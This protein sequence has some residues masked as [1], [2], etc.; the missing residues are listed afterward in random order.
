MEAAA[1]AGDWGWWVT[2][3]NVMH[4]QLLQTVQGRMAH[5]CAAGG[6]KLRSC[7]SAAKVVVVVM[8]VLVLVLVWRL[9]IHWYKYKAAGC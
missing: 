8:E 9:T 6:V 7:C 1:P 5:T 3:S 4:K 2:D